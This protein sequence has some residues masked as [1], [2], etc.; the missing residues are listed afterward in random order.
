MHHS[1][2]VYCK[3]VQLCL[4][5][6]QLLLQYRLPSCLLH[7]GRV[8]LGPMRAQEVEPVQVRQTEGSDQPLMDMCPSH[9]RG[10]LNEY[11]AHLSTKSCELLLIAHQG[12]AIGVQTVSR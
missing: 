5:F 3:Q 11:H 9:L 10:H 8:I 2:I 1:T 7:S 6:E 4:V 12:D